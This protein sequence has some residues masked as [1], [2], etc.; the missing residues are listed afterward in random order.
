MDTSV[1]LV[2]A[3]KLDL[4]D[5]GFKVSTST[6]QIRVLEEPF[7]HESLLLDRKDL[8]LTKQEKRLAKQS[9]EMAKRANMINIRTTYSYLPGNAGQLIIN[10]KQCQWVGGTTIKV[11][12]NQPTSASNVRPGTTATP[13]TA[14]P[15]LMSSLFKQGVMVQKLTMPSN[16]SIPVLTPGAPPVVIPAGQDVLVLR[17]PKGVYL[18][19]PDGRII[20][21]QLPPSL[22]AKT[23]FRPN[24]VTHFRP[25]TPKDRSPNRDICSCT[26]VPNGHVYW[27]GHSSSWP[28]WIVV[29]LSL[30]I[31]SLWGYP[32]DKH[33]FPL[34]CN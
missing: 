17:T 3:F 31:A 33:V 20:A 16:V 4:L 19:L 30:R 25:A 22:L 8:K 27:D 28:S 9:Y 24:V 18:R 32:L 26:S 12:P 6:V 11:L 5:Y 13:I 21:V 2:Q 29:P 34:I 7:E 23:Q 15:S 1:R 14:S 10:N